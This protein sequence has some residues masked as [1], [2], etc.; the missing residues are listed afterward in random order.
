MAKPKDTTPL[1]LPEASEL[2]ARVRRLQTDFGELIDFVRKLTYD[3]P[4]ERSF[5]HMESHLRVACISLDEAANYARNLWEKTE[6][7]AYG[8]TP[9]TEEDKARLREAYQAKFGGIPAPVLWCGYDTDRYWFQ[10]K[11]AVE[12]G[13][14]FED[15]PGIPGAVL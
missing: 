6:H 5:R 2:D 12:T 9:P 3:H 8:F 4:D 15:D 10:I 11:Q 7:A 13:E 1:S 14:P